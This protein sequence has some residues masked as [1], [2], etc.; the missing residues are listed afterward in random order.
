M[1]NPHASVQWFYI[2]QVRENHIKL[3]TSDQLVNTA[4]KTAICMVRYVRGIGHMHT[5]IDCVV[6]KYI[7]ICVDVESVGA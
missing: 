6:F 7:Y 4:L 5:L 2:S 3:H 1:L